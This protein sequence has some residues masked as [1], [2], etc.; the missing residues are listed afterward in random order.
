MSSRPEKLTALRNFVNLETGEVYEDKFIWENSLYEKAVQKKSLDKSISSCNKCSQMN[1]M[2]YSENCPGWGNL[3]S[4]Y[5]FI[6]QSLHRPGMM[7]TL[8]FILGCGYMLDA[9]LRLSGMRR[10]DVFLSNVVHCHPPRN[11]PSTM[12]EK[13]NCLSFL[14]QELEIVQPKMVIALGADAEWAIQKLKMKSSKSQ[15]I[16]KVKHPASFMYSAPELRIEWI[17]KLSTEMDRLKDKK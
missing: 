15:R 14:R 10:H 13:E 12:E 2:R 6:G 4:P 8:P 7:S 1:I 11:R 16:L 3:N 17:I 9:A 5:F